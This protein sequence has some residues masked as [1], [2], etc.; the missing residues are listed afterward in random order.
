MSKLEELKQDPFGYKKCWEC[1]EEKTPLVWVARGKL[2]HLCQ[3]C[4]T[5]T[6]PIFELEG[7]ESGREEP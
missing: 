4:R 6:L 7:T 1:G 5:K 2:V 3:E